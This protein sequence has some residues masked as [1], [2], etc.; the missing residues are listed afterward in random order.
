MCTV[1][2]TKHASSVHCSSWNPID[3]MITFICNRFKGPELKIINE[4]RM[5][6]KIVN[7]SEIMTVDGTSIKLQS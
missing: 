7:L 6:K 3:G 2:S 1:I 4:C 5:F